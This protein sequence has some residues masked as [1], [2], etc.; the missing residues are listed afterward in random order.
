MKIEQD[1]NRF[2]EIIRGKIKK[3]LR[4]YISHSDMI[5]KKGKEYVNIPVPQIDLPRFK[6]GKNNKGLGQGEGNEGDQI[7]EGEEG[8]GG[9]GQAGE[10]PGKH[11]VDVEVTFEELAEMLAEELELPRIEPK[12]NKSLDSTF[13][14]Y[15]G[16]RRTGP[17]SLH[18]FKRTFQQALKRHIASRTYDPE[19]PVIIPIK[20]DKRYKSWKTISVPKSN[21]LILY[22][23]DVSGSMWDE[24]KNIVRTE[25]F[26]INTWVKNHYK[27]VETRYLIHDAAAQEVDEER[28][29]T[30]RE[31]GGTII[32]SAYILAKEILDADYP[33]DE[34]N[35]YLFHF[36]DGDNWSRED[37][38]KSIKII[39][40]NF[41]GKVNFF[42]YGQVES[43]HGSGQFYTDLQSEFGNEEEIILSKIKDRDA[44]PNSI[45]DFF[46]KKK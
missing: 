37:T 24:Q 27:G 30:T 8:Q 34:W 32:S 7:G 31:S 6:Y 36:S 5:G 44:I 23:M 16:I 28:F 29:F 25:A 13:D 41:L 15:S 39:K 2:K 43:P 21:A 46:G 11:L 18:H 4:K 33:A 19:N 22:M 12:G 38:K 1:H 3:N 35:I 45:K 14:K 9:I 20:D 42:G 17:E 10:A 26:W 40:D